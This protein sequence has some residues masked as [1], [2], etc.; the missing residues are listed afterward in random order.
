[1]RGKFLNLQKKKRKKKRK[2]INI[3]NVGQILWPARDHGR[4]WHREMFDKKTKQKNKN[5]KSIILIFLFWEEFHIQ[6]FFKILRL[7]GS[8]RRLKSRI[9]IW[10]F[11][12]Q[13]KEI[14]FR[15]WKYDKRKRLNIHDCFCFHFLTRWTQQTTQRQQQRKKKSGKTAAM[16]STIWFCL[17]QL[18]YIRFF[19]LC[20][21]F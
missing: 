1:M 20:F 7:A 19:F 12:K 10:T 11:K 17:L 9:D 14:H 8:K 16:R 6:F 5:N 15:E 2:E 21:V 18:H 4:D 13:K 3:L